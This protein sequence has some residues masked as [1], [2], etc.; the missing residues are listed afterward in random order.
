MKQHNIVL[1]VF[2]VL[3]ITGCT[4]SGVIEADAKADVVTPVVK[5]QTVYEQEINNIVRIPGVLI[6]STQIKP[7]FKV[8]GTLTNVYVESGDYVEAGEKL[9]KISSAEYE[10]AKLN[11]EKAN[12]AYIDIKEK[13]EDAQALLEVGAITVEN[14]SDI[15][16][17]L[18][19]SE[20]SLDQA[21]NLYKGMSNSETESGALVLLSEIDGYVQSVIYQ[22]SENIAGG[23]PIAVVCSN[24]TVF[25]CFATAKE[26]LNIFEGMEV[27]LEFDN[28]TSTGR[29]LRIYDMPDHSTGYYGVEIEVSVDQPIG[30]IGNAFLNLGTKKGIWLSVNTIENDGTDFVY[31]IEEERVTRRNINIIDIQGNMLKVNGLY[32][33]DK[34]VIENAQSIMVGDLVKSEDVDVK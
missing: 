29:V 12:N 3:S 33:H 10:N 11:F 7:S 27:E 25:K 8:S 22:V 21:R 23:A 4:R 5:I 2:L 9:A 16:A 30:M 31:V 20:L 1:I 6:S 18:M 17:Q 14:A 26:V 15:Q 24:E 34:V 19:V 32:P 28:S 13:Y